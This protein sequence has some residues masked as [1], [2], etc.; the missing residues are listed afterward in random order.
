V[1]WTTTLVVAAL[2]SLCAV[3]TGSMTVEVRQGCLRWYFG[4]GISQWS[5]PLDDI[6]SVSVWR[7][8]AW[9]WGIHDTPDGRLY[10]VS[11][12]QGV[13][14]KLSSGRR[15]ILGTDR[16]EELYAVLKS[17]HWSTRPAIGLGTPRRRLTR[18][19][20]AALGV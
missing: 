17:S 14:V 18:A 3:A 19:S 7:S 8:D 10:N 9:R 12:R 1:T 5:V 11:G 16:P 2:L 20:S 15:I 6:V 13:W 4:P